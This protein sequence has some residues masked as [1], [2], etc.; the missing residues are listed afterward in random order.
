MNHEIGSEMKAVPKRAITVEPRLSAEL[1]RWH[2][3]VHV[4]MVNRRRLVG[5]LAVAMSHTAQVL[6]A[7]PAPVVVRKY[8]VRQHWDDLTNFHV[9]AVVD[10]PGEQRGMVP[11]IE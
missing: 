10:P 9:Y 11:T 1:P 6:H 2:N 5:P 3:H 7:Q 8:H 4:E